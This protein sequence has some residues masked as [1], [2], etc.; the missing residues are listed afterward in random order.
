MDSR[1]RGLEKIVVV[2]EKIVGIPSR[3]ET[4]ESR[5]QRLIKM[6]IASAHDGRVNS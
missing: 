2:E 3:D 4:A 6:V 5:G 1:I